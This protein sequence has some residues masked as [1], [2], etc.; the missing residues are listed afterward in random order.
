MET[1]CFC[2]QRR[3]L[4]Q[5]TDAEEPSPINNSS[6]LSLP[7]GVWVRMPCSSFSNEKKSSLPCLW[8]PEHPRWKVL[9]VK[10]RKGSPDCFKGT[11][12][13]TLPWG[14]NNRSHKVLPFS[15]DQLGDYRFHRQRKAEGSGIKGAPNRMNQKR[16]THTIKGDLLI[17]VMNCMPTLQR[18]V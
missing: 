14:N 5:P 10:K 2:W 13:G 18:S 7:V 12:D 15:L 11:K 9:P 1:S 4:D 17:S 8:F 6:E 16:V 3:G